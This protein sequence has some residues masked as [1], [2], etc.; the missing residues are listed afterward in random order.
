MSRARK[1]L[2][3]PAKKSRKAKTNP[4]RQA[5]MRSNDRSDDNWFVPTATEAEALAAL[6][7]ATEGRIVAVGMSDNL[8]L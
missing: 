8:R 6:F 5:G 4:I 3:A 2:K 1:G 7:G